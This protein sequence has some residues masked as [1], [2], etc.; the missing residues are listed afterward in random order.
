MV[1][2]IYLLTDC[3]Q[4]CRDARFWTVFQNMRGPTGPLRVEDSELRLRLDDINKVRVTVVKDLV[5]AKQR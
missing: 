1:S 3:L 5:A 4:A 2:A